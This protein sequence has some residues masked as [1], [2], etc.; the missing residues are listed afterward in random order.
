MN[1]ADIAQNNSHMLHFGVSA[2]A[3]TLVAFLLLGPISTGVRFSKLILSLLH[4]SPRKREATI[5]QVTPIG[6]TRAPFRPLHHGTAANIYTQPLKV[7]TTAVPS[8]DVPIIATQV[9]IQSHS[10]AKSVPMNYRKTRVMWR[11]VRLQVRAAPM[12]VKSRNAILLLLQ[13]EHAL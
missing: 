2:W 3:T 9:S 1:T 7:S 5:A 12:P 8:Q 11:M 10:T 13:E 4:V 6:P